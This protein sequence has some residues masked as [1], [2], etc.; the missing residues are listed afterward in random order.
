MKTTTAK[1]IAKQV[2]YGLFAVVLL[3]TYYPNV[4]SAAQIT[5]RSVVIGSSIASATTT[6]SF[7]F[8]V[9]ST[10][11]V[12]S[13]SFTACTTASGTCT[14]PAG[15]SVASSTLTAQPTNLGDASGWTVSTA[16]PGSLRLSKS[17]NVATPTGAQTVG[18]SGVVNP[19]T[20]NATFFVR[21]AT[22]SDATWTTAIDA[23]TVATSTAG[24]VTVTVVID[25]S[26][27]FTLANTTVALNTP[28]TSSTGTGTSAMT[29][30][31]NAVNGYS[32]GYSGTTLT[33]GA[34]T[35]NAMSSPTASTVNSKQFGLNLMNNT[36]PAVGTNV[37][38]V[39]SGTP[40]TGYNTTNLFKFNSGDTIASAA[41]P[42]NDN[43]Y[44]ASYIV[45]M[46]GATAAGSYSTLLTYIAT[47]NF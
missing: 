28:T 41:L 13:A 29:V 11:V 42:T 25:E 47:S 39:G 22:Y 4:A 26:L 30:S 3:L 31:T 18:F 2:S 38:G 15:F 7:G 20:T 33:S 17:A 45:N 40:A 35:I 23:G 12:K 9:P 24:Q 32:V 36:T 10:T 16:T 21:M 27:T 1:S 8:T 34:N 19:S 37:T 5:A 43:V 44:T 14:T 6:Y 46:N